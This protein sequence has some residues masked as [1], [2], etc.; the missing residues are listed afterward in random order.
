MQTSEIKLEIFRYIDNLEISKLTQIYNLIISNN[1]QLDVDFW[2]TLNEW[3]K[4]DIELGLTDLKQGNKRNFD[5]VML[6][7]Q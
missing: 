1:Q 6:K 4:N 3:Q 2:N 7:Y 5:E